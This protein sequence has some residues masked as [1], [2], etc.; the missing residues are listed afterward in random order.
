[1]SNNENKR[2]PLLCHWADQMADTIIREKGDLDSYTCASGITP[3][4]TVHLGNFREIITVDLVVRA[5][6]DRG[7]NVRFIYSWDDYDVFRKVPANMPDPEILE[8]YL[9]F[10]ITEVPDTTNRNENYARH[11]EVDIE[12]QL[13]RVGIAPEFLYQ[14]SRYRANRYAEGMKKAMQMR[15]TIKECLNEYRDDAHKMKPEDEYWPVAIF[16]GKCSKDTTNITG[17]DGEYGIS[18]K[19][20]CG[21]EETADIRTFKGAKL[22][23]RVDWPMRW[24]EEKVVFEPGGKD[25]ISPGGS[26]DTA[27]LVSKKIYGWDAPVTMRYDFVNLKGVPGKMSSSK[28]KVIALPDALDVYQAEVLRYLFAGTRPN[29]EFAISFDMDVLK[30]YEDYDK[31]E[32]IVYGVDKAKNEDQFNKEKRIYMLSQIDGKIPE[33]MPYQITFRMLTT[34]LQTYSGDIDAVIKSLKD[35]KP[36]QEERLRRRMACAWFWIQNSAPSCA[37]DFIFTIRNDGSKADL[38]ETMSKAVARVRDEVVP[39]LDTFTQDKECQQAMYDIATD[40]G[41]DAKQLFTALY[42]AV[43]AKDQGPRLGGFFRIIGKE[44]LEK[45][46]KDY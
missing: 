24:N 26:Y 21:H 34:L 6:R 39:K 12:Q 15:E 38:D 33:T 3:S 44:R 4:G 23:W 32:R 13:P 18:Y 7:K 19:C 46:L 1:M 25:H 35:V 28:G 45:I 29:T 10:P 31:T 30:V 8:K 37:E 41:I 43:V 17:Y 9:R 11:H 2:D 22:G 5:L 40:M 20:E 36:E 27:K 14:A 42:Q 16:C